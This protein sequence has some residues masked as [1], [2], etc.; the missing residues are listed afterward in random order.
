MTRK[1]KK[2]TL[3]IV[4]KSKKSSKY[5][6]VCFDRAKNKYMSYVSVESKTIHLGRFDDEIEAATIR[7][8]Y[9][10]NNNLKYRLN[11]S[12]APLNSI[13]NSKLISLNNGM[14]AIVDDDDFERANDMYWWAFKHRNTWYAI[15]SILCSDSLIDIKLHRFILNVS[16]PSILIDHENGNGLDCR[17]VNLRIVTNIQ[18][19]MN[20]RKANGLFTSK[21][22]GVS[23]HKRTNKFLCRIRVNGSLIH[24]GYF[25]SEDVAAEIYD[26][27]AI[28]YFGEFARLNFP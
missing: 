27:N 2:V 22:K 6:G 23:F 3:K 5:I 28:K 9:V 10:L 25:I 8:T 17:K 4:N 24:L 1:W 11:F 20:Q 7:D 15:G 13:P 26:K 16:D 14:F 19:C 21:Y 12:K 18:N